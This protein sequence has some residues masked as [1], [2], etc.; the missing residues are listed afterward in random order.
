VRLLR[1]LLKTNAEMAGREIARAVGLAQRVV[2]SALKNLREQGTVGMRR[3][4][5]ATLYRINTENILV[6]DA[7]R[8]LFSF[9]E[10]LLSY[11]ARLLT[12][13]IGSDMISAVLF[14]SIAAGAE[15]ADSDIDVLIVIKDRADK[16][17]IEKILDELSLDVSKMFGN[18][19]SPVVIAASQLKQRYRR[20]DKFIIDMVNEGKVISGK[21][22][23]ESIYE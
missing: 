22:F 1:F 4:G 21:T 17:R 13:R 19:F 8:P 5:R 20:R 10:K 15:K 23:M 9:E 6:T 18:F 14:G 12:K 11:L 3:V 7:L 16:G 2:H